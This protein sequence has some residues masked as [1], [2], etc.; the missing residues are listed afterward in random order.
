MRLSVH[1]ILSS[2]VISAKNARLTDEVFRAPTARK[3]S[4][5][6]QNQEVREK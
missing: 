2:P 3:E 6:E 1:A 5:A 4:Q